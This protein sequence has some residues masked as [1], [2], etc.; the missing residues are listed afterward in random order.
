MSEH[1]VVHQFNL[2]GYQPPRLRMPKKEKA[3]LA[4]LL[5]ESKALFEAGNH[6]HSVVKLRQF[7]E[8]LDNFANRITNGA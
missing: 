6:K 8:G 7:R 1:K 5:R 2:F 4:K 3:K